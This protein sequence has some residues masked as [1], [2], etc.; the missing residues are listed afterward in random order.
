ML[1]ITQALWG[2][3]DSD[4]SLTALM[5]WSRKAIILPLESAQIFLDDYQTIYCLTFAIYH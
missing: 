5:P 4:N 2:L 3:D 1:L